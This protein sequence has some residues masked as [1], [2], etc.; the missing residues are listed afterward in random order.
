MT[1][2]RVDSVFERLTMAWGL[3]MRSEGPPTLPDSSSPER[4]SGVGRRGC[5]TERALPLVLIASP[6]LDSAGAVSENTFKAHA[7][8]TALGAGEQ[9]RCLAVTPFRPV[10]LSHLLVEFQ[11]RVLLID[12][13]LVER[14]GTEELRRI[15]RRMPSVDCVL[16]WDEPSEGILELAMR[17][18]MRGGEKWNASPQH[19]ERAVMAVMAGEVWFPRQTM[20]SLYMSLIAAIQTDGTSDR[21]PLDECAPGR[22]PSYGKAAALTPREVDAIALVRQGLSNKQIAERLDISVNTVKK[23][24]ARAFEKRGLNNRRQAMA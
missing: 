23:H 11:P 20:Q 16:L 2:K 21:M 22:D 8:A 15:Q 1:M 9:L 7:I 13:V 19:L 17:A 5:A 10:D 6:S 14:M 24:L 4:V 12:M 3:A 18:Q